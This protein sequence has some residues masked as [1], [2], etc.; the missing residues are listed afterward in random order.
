MTPLSHRERRERGQQPLRVLLVEDSP[1]LVQ[2]ISEL[3]EDLPNIEL[4]GTAGTEPEAVAR[5]DAGDVDAVILDLQLHTGSGFGVLRAL[6]R[7]GTGPAVI[8]FTNFAIGA[9]RETAFALGARHFLDKS[10]DYDRLP[11]VLQELSESVQ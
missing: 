1:L 6:Q 9:Y 8:V 10:R 3:V 2:R 4:V 11:A 5:L 7:R